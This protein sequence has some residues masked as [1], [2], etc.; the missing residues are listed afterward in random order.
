MNSHHAVDAPHNHGLLDRAIAIVHSPEAPLDGGRV[1]ERW[2]AFGRWTLLMIG[3][4]LIVRSRS[5]THL[6]RSDGWEDSWKKST[7]VVRSNR[8]RGAI[9]PRS[10]LFHRGINATIHGARFQLKTAGEKST[11]EARSPLDR[12]HDQARSWLLLK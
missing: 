6:K 4:Y 2:T 1:S 5:S 7:I 12:D 10:W 9:E 3:D 11:I 8:D